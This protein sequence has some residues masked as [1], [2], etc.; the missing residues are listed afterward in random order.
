MT[1]TYA[2]FANGTPPRIIASE[3]EYNAAGMTTRAIG[4]M[5]SAS[6][7]LSDYISADHYLATGRH[8]STSVATK[9]GGEL[10]VDCNSL[11]EYATPEC[12][13]A[14]TLLLHERAGELIV[15]STVTR[16][17]E[18]Y[19]WRDGVY[20]RTGYTRTEIDSG[21]VRAA[22]SA[23]HHENYFFAHPK[24]NSSKLALAKRALCSY[25]AT[26]PIWSGAGMITGDGF[27][28]SQ[29]AD[30]INFY[31]S[32]NL[33][34]HGDKTPLRLHPSE[35]RLEVR[36][37]EG[38]MS[39]WAIVQKFAMT[40][41]VLRLIEHRRFPSDLLLHDFNQS[42]RTI[43]DN[44][45]ATVYNHKEEGIS[46]IDHQRRIAEAAFDFVIDHSD[47]VPSDEETA[48]YEILNV[49]DDL[50]RTSIQDNDVAAVQNRVDWAAKFAHITSIL[51]PSELSVDNI[52][53]IYHDLKWEDISHKSPSKKWFRNNG[54]NLVNSKQVA[55][56]AITPPV[57]RARKRVRLVQ[58]LLE[59]NI[60]VQHVNWDSVNISE[61]DLWV[62]GRSLPPNIGRQTVGEGTGVYDA[63]VLRDP[64]DYTL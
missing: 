11:F 27:S 54:I 1:H 61:Q 25:L 58:E 57:T 3:T 4:C 16:L 39:D 36:T 2:E 49:C 38:N 45:D 22:D 56:A 47:T 35:S 13:D 15:A 12:I 6:I 53:A 31:D 60:A 63:I 18:D 24:P 51:D 52:L 41:L 59:A 8:P 30:G 28:I 43:T 50:D 10:Y 64:Y 55:N 32:T 29:K 44:P 40:S 46:A 23:G 37:G 5:D 17:T 14:R 42:I 62:N 33:T 20:K 9:N 34:T 7:D 21:T 26:R 19:K 48:V